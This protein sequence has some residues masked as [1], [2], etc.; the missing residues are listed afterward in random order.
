[1]E[2][3]TLSCMILTCSS[4]LITLVELPKKRLHSEDSKKAESKADW[5][6]DRTLKA[7]HPLVRLH[8]EILDYCEYVTPKG[9]EVNNRH[10]A[11]TKVTAVAKKCWPG[12]EVLVFGSFATNLSLFNSDVDLVLYMISEM[13]GYFS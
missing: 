4:L 12:C 9:N 7:T 6:T 3:S 10:T 13:L 1:M 11:I 5:I 8:N 2:P